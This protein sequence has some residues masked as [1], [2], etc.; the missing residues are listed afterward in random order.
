MLYRDSKVKLADVLDGTTQTLIVG[1]Q[2]FGTSAWIAGMSSSVNWPCNMS[3]CKNVRFGINVDPWV[4]WNDRSFAS[5]HPGGAQFAMS[6]GSVEFLTENIDIT[7]YLSLA[8]RN[9]EEIT[10]GGRN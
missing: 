8:S 3:C 10:A 9:G 5:V 6:G 2:L 7:V 1:E 4:P